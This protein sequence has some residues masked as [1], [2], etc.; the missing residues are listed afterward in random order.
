[1]ITLEVSPE[2]IISDPTAEWMQHMHSE[3]GEDQPYYH[4]QALCLKFIRVG[5]TILASPL[6]WTTDDRRRWAPVTT[7]DQ[8]AR[9]AE[10]DPKTIADAGFFLLYLTQ[11]ELSIYG[12][13]TIPRDVNE[14]ER[15]QTLELMERKVGDDY[16]VVSLR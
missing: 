6:I 5:Y 11:N 3:R 7:H 15:N 10:I 14:A 12:S 9:A 16:S 2:S 4:G 13:R 8:I 1:M